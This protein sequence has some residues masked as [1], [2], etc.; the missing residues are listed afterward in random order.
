MVARAHRSVADRGSLVLSLGFRVLVG[1]KGSF[2]GFHKGTYKGF[3]VFRVLGSWAYW[4]LG[5]RVLSCFCVVFLVS[6]S[7]FWVV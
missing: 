7:R 6:G 3:R 1:F 5:F 4:V 2:K